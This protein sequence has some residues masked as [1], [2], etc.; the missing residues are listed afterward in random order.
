MV[1]D[2]SAAS[3]IVN[4]ASLFVQWSTLEGAGCT[5]AFDSEVPA[6]ARGQYL[7]GCGSDEQVESGHIGCGGGGRRKGASSVAAPTTHA[8]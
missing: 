3:F 4:L 1:R 2:V 5:S 7:W 6:G 8:S